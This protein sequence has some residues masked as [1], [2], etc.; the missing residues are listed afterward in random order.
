MVIPRSWQLSIQFEQALVLQALAYFTL[1]GFQVT[2]RVVRVDGIDLDAETEL[3]LEHGPCTHQQLDTWPDL[4][5]GRQLELGE[6]LA[7]RTG[8]DDGIGLG[9]DDS[10]NVAL[11]DLKVHMAVA[12]TR[13]YHLNKR[14][15]PGFESLRYR[16]RDALQQLRQRYPLF[17]RD[18]QAPGHGRGRRQQITRDYGC[19]HICSTQPL[20]E[21]RKVSA[22]GH[23]PLSA[24]RIPTCAQR[25]DAVFV[26]E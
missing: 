14:P 7:G 22:L 16:P 2:Q 21:R 1:A 19:W 3:R 17:F 5:T 20:R 25:L 10:R 11:G 18:R 24:S 4:G 13:I 12:N 6:N 15:N 26:R 9:G 23:E 8:P